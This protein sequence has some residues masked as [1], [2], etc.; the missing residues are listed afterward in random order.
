MTK[1]VTK[2]NVET[3]PTVDLAQFNVP[4]ILVVSTRATVLGETPSVTY[5]TDPSAGILG[6][7]EYDMCELKSDGTIGNVL[8]EGIRFPIG[9][10]G[11]MNGS[12]EVRASDNRSFDHVKPTKAMKLHILQTWASLRGQVTHAAGSL[13][14][15]T[16]AEEVVAE[17]SNEMDAALKAQATE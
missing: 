3:V 10:F 12:R 11:V 17:I 13:T 8:I 7:I 1:V 14:V 4:G 16:P 5:S 9:K 2:T 6:N 15:A